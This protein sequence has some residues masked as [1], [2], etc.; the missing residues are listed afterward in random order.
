MSGRCGTVHMASC[1]RTGQSVAIKLIDAVDE[2]VNGEVHVLRA[3]AEAVDDDDSD[4]GDNDNDE[5]SGAIAVAEY[6]EHCDVP[7]PA[8]SLGRVREWRRAI[9]MNY[10]PGEDLFDLSNRWWR[11]R[12]VAPPRDM[13]RRLLA[14]SLRGL[15]FLHARGIGHRDVKPENIRVVGDAAYAV[16][17]DFGFSCSVRDTDDSD[18]KRQQLP[19]SASRILAATP[20]YT[21]PERAR[22]ISSSLA[23]RKDRRETQL[24]DQLGRLTRASDVW[25]MATAFHK[26]L[27]G[28]P[29]PG[30]MRER[31]LCERNVCKRTE[32]DLLLDFVSH[33]YDGER[34]DPP[35]PL[36]MY[37]ED[38]C[39]DAIVR[40]MLAHD[41][42]SRVTAGGAL[43]RLLASDDTIKPSCEHIVN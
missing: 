12:R 43:D 14:S 26:L 35:A 15:A 21:S 40:D 20:C 2:H 4:T 38:A 22:L 17:I 31:E 8:P 5:E 27:N 29:S 6:R 28:A 42:K 37:K 36:S 39:V 34:S 9:V 16:L 1:R 7:W 32:R 41:W 25:S 33:L 24:P 19:S 3:L 11:T 10:V 18:A 23:A 13:I 30:C